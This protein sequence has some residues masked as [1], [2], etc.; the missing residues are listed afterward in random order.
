VSD[1]KPRT[2]GPYATER[3]AIADAFDPRN[4]QLVKTWGH[5]ATANGIKLRDVCEEAGVELGAYDERIVD[6]LSRWEP[7]AVQVIVGLISRA[8]AR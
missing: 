8:G 4:A 1:Q 7:Q 3:E 5:Q 2:F 6:W